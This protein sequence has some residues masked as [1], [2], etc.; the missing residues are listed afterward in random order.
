MMN[1]SGPDFSKLVLSL[2]KRETW[3]M[4]TG[5]VLLAPPSFAVPFLL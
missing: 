3:D 5:Q 4:A 1:T 2:E